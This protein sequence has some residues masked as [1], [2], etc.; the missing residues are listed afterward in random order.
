[1]SDTVHSPENLE[2]FP[3]I[4]FAAD[5]AAALTGLSVSQLRRWDRTGFFPPW[6]ADPNRR[7]PYSRL[8][9]LD[10]V[11]ALRTIAKLREAGVSFANVK[12]IVPMLE[13]KPDGE[14]PVRC[15]Y[16]VGNRVF[17]SRD[18]AAAARPNAT[19]P[20]GPTVLALSSVMAEVET[21]VERLRHRTPEQIGTVTRNRGIMR[22]APVIAG[23]RIP[24]ATIAWFHDSGYALDWILK[25]F[26]RLT[27]EDV[28]VA[29]DFERAGEARTPD[30]ALAHA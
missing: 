2:T 28:R 13:P 3:L 30:P 15:F 18:E 24:T 29:V 22:G 19:A 26:P 9:S 20:D 7:R 4:A 21:A 5:T 1:M 11:I 14:W 17:L 23:T 10:N 27:A 25:E 12:P 6:R 16:V 8:Y